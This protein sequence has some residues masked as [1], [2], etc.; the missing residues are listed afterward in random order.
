MKCPHCGADHPEDA[1]RF[2]NSCGMSVIK[3]AGP[4]APEEEDGEVKVRCRYCGVN[5][6][7]PFCPLCG[8]KLPTPEELEEEI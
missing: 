6:K 3:Y 7:P 2:C 1:G 5:V 4:E 8:N